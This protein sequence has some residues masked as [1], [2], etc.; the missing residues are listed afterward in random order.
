MARAHP[1]E[2]REEVYHCSQ[3]GARALAW[4]CGTDLLRD[5]PARPTD[6]V[7]WHCRKALRVWYSQDNPT[8]NGARQ[9]DTHP[10]E[11]DWWLKPLLWQRAPSPVLMYVGREVGREGGCWDERSQ[12]DPHFSW[13][14]PGAPETPPRLR[15]APGS[16]GQRCGGL[17]LGYVLV[18]KTQRGPSMGLEEEMASVTGFSALRL[19]VRQNP[20]GMSPSTPL[21][22]HETVKGI[23]S[24]QTGHSQTHVFKA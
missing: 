14:R 1:R 20:R 9:N 10:K 4:S 22:G 2:E 13:E 16:P 5:V 11:D 3:R 19:F 23:F 24:R 7:H 18:V 15:C 17:V 21:W 8:G 12:A 6:S